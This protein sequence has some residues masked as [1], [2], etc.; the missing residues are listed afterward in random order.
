MA[1]ATAPGMFLR[2]VDQARV[3]DLGGALDVGGLDAPYRGEPVAHDRHARGLVARAAVRLGREVGAV[4]LE[5]ERRRGS[6]FAT[7]GNLEFLYV[8]G[9]PMPMRKPRSS[10]WRASSTPPGKGVEDPAD[11]RGPLLAENRYRV[12]EGLARVDDDRFLEIERDPDLP[13]EYLAL[14]LPRRKIA[15]VI[16][17]RLADG[18]DLLQEKPLLDP[19]LDGLVPVLRV[20]RVYAERAV[21][22]AVPP[23]ERDRV[24]DGPRVIADLEHLP[25]ARRAGA[26]DDVVEVVLE[27]THVEMDVG[28]D[29]HAR[30]NPSGDR[31]CPP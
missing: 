13:P 30:F 1:Y 23:G 31:R 3:V 18:D 21:N 27:L 10:A 29:E 25:H 6:I 19:L 9:P 26:R 8:S 14:P 24:V 7:S 12:V 2:L 28:V 5:D 22:L 11:L 15:V 20:V 17:P 16:E 4:G